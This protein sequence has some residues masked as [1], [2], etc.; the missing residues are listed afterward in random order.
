[1]PDDGVKV[2]TIPDIRWA[3]CDIK[4]IAVLPNIL[5]KQAA[6]EADASEAWMID[7]DDYVTEGTSSNAWI[8]TAENILVTQPTGH[9]ILAGITRQVILRLAGELGYTVE[10]RAFTVAEAYQ[11]KEAFMSNSSHFVTQVTPFGGKS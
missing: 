11:A 2:L 7:G 4:S 5:G 10:E 8:V 3:R 9:R 1:M 6:A